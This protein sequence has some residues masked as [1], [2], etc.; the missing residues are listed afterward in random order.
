M[1]D[2]A[3][4]RKAMVD[5]QVRPN[6]VTDRR[7]PRAMLKVERERF[8]PASRRAVT[9][10][11]GPIPLTDGRPARSLLAARDF[12]KMVQSLAVPDDAAVLDLG[13]GT[14]Y[15]TAILA[16]LARSVVAVEPDP[17]L[18][19]RAKA[20]LAGTP[21]VTV[22]SGPL[23]A[24]APAEG[25]FDAILLN[26]AVTHMPASLLDQLKDGGRLV[27]VLAGGVGRAT[28]WQRHGTRFDRR[29]LFDAAA[30]VLPGFE[31][32]VEFVF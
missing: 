5:S 21:G 19:E 27:A 31:S 29:P 9:Y 7:I 4:Q 15:T 11:D 20:L 17:A 1:T 30:P 23:P 12:S 16:E 13:C 28:L 32:K 6:D 24:G 26:G 25:P 2:F 14:G 10:M 22:L 18:A 3:T 8:V